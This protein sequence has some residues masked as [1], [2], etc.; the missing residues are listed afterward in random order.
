MIMDFIECPGQ[1]T[2]FLISSK[3]HEICGYRRKK[4]T[5]SLFTI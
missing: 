4:K 2:T 1:L 3:R 5:G